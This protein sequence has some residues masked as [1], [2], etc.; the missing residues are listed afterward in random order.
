M[1]PPPASEERPSPPRSGWSFRI[2]TIAGIPI[3]VHFTFLL[4]LVWV[5]LL[6]REKD[7]LV[8][9]LLL[10]AIFVC[11]LLHELGH[12]LVAK[13]YGVMTR[14]ITLYPMGGVAALEGRPKPNE[15]FWIALAGP[16][17]NVAIAIVLGAIVLWQDKRLPPLTM[18]LQ[19]LGFIEGLYVANVILPVFNMIPAFPMDGGRVL[20][21]FLAM[22]IPEDRATRIAAGIGQLL[23]IGLGVAGLATN[24]ILLMLVAFFVFVGASQE[25]TALV[26]HRLIEGKTVRDAMMTEFRTVGS[27]ESL[28]LAARHLLSGSQHDFPVTVGEDL[29]GVLTRQDLV[30][31]LAD[32][33]GGGYVAGHMTRDFK[34]VSP[35]QSL[36][37]AILDITGQN[38]VPILVMEGERLIGMLTGDNLSEFLMIQQAKSASHTR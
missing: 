8:I 28:D 4:F 26:G 22:N 10:P 31:G 24:N 11:V 33:G 12:A 21:A 9:A 17:V 15:E 30:R 23:A 18:S 35:D 32:E 29:V 7:G 27:G 14:D 5:G 1:T 6:G 3:R 13:R 34:R 2:L 16:L 36:E 37:S 25:V 20:R 38:K 19:G